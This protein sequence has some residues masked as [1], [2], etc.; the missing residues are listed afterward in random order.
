MKDTIMY[1]LTSA[2]SNLLVPWY[3][4]ASYAY[5]HLD[6][7]ILS[8]AAFDD[9]AK[10]LLDKYETIEHRHKHLITKG[11]LRAGSLLLTKSE[12]PSIVMGSLSIL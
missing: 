2:N 10:K 11:D 5:Y 7:P 9:I 3:L 1:K 8:D 6:D 12:Y 4:L